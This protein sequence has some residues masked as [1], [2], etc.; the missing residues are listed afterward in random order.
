[1]TTLITAA[2]ETSKAAAWSALQIPQFFPRALC[3][4]STKGS[5]SHFSSSP[6]PPP[7]S[8][9]LARAKIKSQ[10]QKSTKV[11]K[12]RAIPAYDPGVTPA[13]IVS[14]SFLLIT[15]RSCNWVWKEG[16]GVGGPDP[17]FPLLFHEN[18]DSRTFLT[19]FPNPVFSF[20]QNTLK[21]SFPKKLI[22]VRSDVSNA[23]LKCDQGFRSNRKKGQ[24]E[25]ICK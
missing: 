25:I 23:R 14:F 12:S 24:Q 3:Y 13:D 10:Q 2:K 11:N 16:G 18:S 19:A 1:M 17:A 8:P 5:N 4:K 20:P 7:N 6:P 15:L 22:H 21:K 9:P